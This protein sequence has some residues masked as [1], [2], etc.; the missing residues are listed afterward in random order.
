MKLTIHTLGDPVLRQKT[1]PVPQVDA[2]IRTLAADM[3]ETMYAEEGIGLAAPQIGESISL[4][5]VDVPVEGDTD[6]EGRRLN[7]A[8]LMPMVLVN[9]EVLDRSEETETFEEGCL[10]LPD[11]RA[12]ISRPREVTVRWTTLDGGTETQRLRGLIGRCVQHELDHLAGVL[13]CDRMS[14]VKKVAL[15]GAMKRLT[16]ETRARLGV[17]D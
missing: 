10:S 1:E 13:I 9:P 4:C 3:I 7:P 15:R 17:V 16:R 8:A 12:P 5:V 14:P 6:D 2:R 11:I